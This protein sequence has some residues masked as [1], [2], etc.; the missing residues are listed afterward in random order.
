[1]SD[2][3]EEH[4]IRLAKAGDPAAAPMIVSYLAE[5][6]LG[7]AHGL[8]PNLPDSDRERIVELAVEAGLRA[9]DRFDQTRGSLFSWFRRQVAF[10]TADWHRTAPAMLT[11]EMAPDLV[12][13]FTGMMRTW[14]H[15]LCPSASVGLAAELPAVSIVRSG[16]VVGD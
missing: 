13:S 16:S 1:M 15:Q 7:Y 6:L 2:D 10:R 4:L 11:I 9:F 12:E 14:N 5:R 8:A 3:L